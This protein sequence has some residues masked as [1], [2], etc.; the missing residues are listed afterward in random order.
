MCVCLFVE[1][2][3]KGNNSNEKPQQIN[4]SFFEI[5]VTTLCVIMLIAVF[6][7]PRLVKAGLFLT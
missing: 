5:L 4:L 1:K 2:A 3:N 6:G 7:I